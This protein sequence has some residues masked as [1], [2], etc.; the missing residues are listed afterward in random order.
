MAGGNGRAGHPRAATTRRPRE[1]VC[2]GATTVEE[3][4]PKMPTPT[5]TKS[6]RTVTLTEV[7]RVRAV[8]ARLEACWPDLTAAQQL[9]A[10]ALLGELA[11]V[12][13]AGTRQPI[14]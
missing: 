4:P 12:Y 10:L 9:E 14:T 3:T 11:R 6:T 2:P 13:R 7:G 8:M 1:R 5:T